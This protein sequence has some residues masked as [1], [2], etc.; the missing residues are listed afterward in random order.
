LKPG[1]TFSE[2]EGRWVQPTVS[3]TKSAYQSSVFWVGIDGVGSRSVE[4]VGTAAD[5][6]GYATKDYYAWFDMAPKFLVRI[7][8]V[9]NPGD[10]MFG[11][12]SV[13]G[14]TFTLSLINETTGGHYTR[15]QRAVADRVSAE[16]IAE[17]TSSCPF[18]ACV[19][20]ALPDFGYVRFADC[21]ATMDGTGSG[22]SAG[23]WD[24]SPT[25]MTNK[26]RHAIT[27]AEPS[28]LAITGDAFTV[29]WRKSGP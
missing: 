7:A 14:N 11:R 10:V 12:V 9:V 27:K 22:L 29:A 6:V 18:G 8:M 28:A 13:S 15:R 16:W 25:V 2:V 20:D 4:Q 17:A 1:S 21:R 23:G 19:V 3:C 26:F 24:L 5:C